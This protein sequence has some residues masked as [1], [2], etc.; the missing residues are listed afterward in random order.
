M[1]HQHCQNGHAETHHFTWQPL[2]WISEQ[3]LS[4]ASKSNQRLT[5]NFSLQTPNYTWHTLSWILLLDQGHLIYTSLATSFKPK[6]QPPKLLSCWIL[7]GL[8]AKPNMPNASL[9]L[10]IAQQQFCCQILLLMKSVTVMFC[11]CITKCMKTH[12]MLLMN[13]KLMKSCTFMSSLQFML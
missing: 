13:Y 1:I 11:Y 9:T 8:K 10:C 7:E 4:L 5:D 2:A 6:N 12:L 3:R